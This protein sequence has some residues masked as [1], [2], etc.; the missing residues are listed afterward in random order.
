MYRNSRFGFQSTGSSE[1]GVSSAFGKLA[2]FLHKLQQQGEVQCWY[3][4]DPGSEQSDCQD[5]L[6]RAQ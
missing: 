4:L 6:Q 3:F 2:I 5:N 1:D